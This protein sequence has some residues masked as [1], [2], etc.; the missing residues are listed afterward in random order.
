MLALVS[1]LVQSLEGLRYGMSLHLGLALFLSR[2]SETVHRLHR[3]LSLQL[4]VHR[5]D[6][7]IHRVFV[8]AIKNRYVIFVE[9]T[10]V[11]RAQMD[12]YL[13]KVSTRYSAD[14]TDRAGGHRQKVY[15]EYLSSFLPKEWNDLTGCIKML[16]EE[17]CSEELSNVYQHILIYVFQMKQLGQP[18]CR[19][20]YNI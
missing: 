3:N 20:I 13:A 14:E 9:G 18:H 19:L 16:L 7:W 5:C 11:T 15:H 10:F 8:R 2:Q 4:N 17:W 1:A 6:R 12:L